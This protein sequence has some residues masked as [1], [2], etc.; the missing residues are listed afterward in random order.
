[1]KEEV[2]H[3]IWDQF[4]L[5]YQVNRR[6]NF[7]EGYKFLARDIPKQRSINELYKLNKG[8]A[9]YSKPILD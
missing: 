4:I 5:W 8:E 9:L 7:D 3:A 6:I 2:F 1:M